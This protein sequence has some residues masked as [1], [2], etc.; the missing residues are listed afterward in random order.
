MMESRAPVW[1]RRAQL[2]SCRVARLRRRGAIALGVVEAEATCLGV[3]E[4]CGAFRLS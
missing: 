2:A 4:L 3:E 1:R